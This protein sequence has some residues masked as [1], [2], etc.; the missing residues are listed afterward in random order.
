MLYWHSA[1]C[2]ETTYTI[3]AYNDNDNTS[4]YSPDHVIETKRDKFTDE[5]N[6]N[7][8]KTFSAAVC[9]NN[10]ITMKYVILY[11]YITTSRVYYYY[12]IIGILVYDCR[13]TC[14][15]IITN[16]DNTLKSTWR[17]HSLF[18]S[19]SAAVSIAV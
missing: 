19:R 17:Y 13:R 1:Q 10:I 12:Y 11:R 14:N 9:V 2:R 7:F 3:F 5:K 4:Y 6:K 16:N 8:M 18:D 15:D